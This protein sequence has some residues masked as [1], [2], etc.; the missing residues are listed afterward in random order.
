MQFTLMQRLTCREAYKRFGEDAQ[1]LKAVEECNEL[2]T[3]LMHL[4]DGKADKYAVAAELADV[5]IMI[6]QLADGLDINIVK[7]VDVKTARLYDLVHSIDDVLECAECGH[8]VPDDDMITE[9]QAIDDHGGTE[10]VPVGYLCAECEHQ[11]LF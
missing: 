6:E 11:E 7:Y 5:L 4:R 3:A 8:N 2:A 9:A 1:I 10:S